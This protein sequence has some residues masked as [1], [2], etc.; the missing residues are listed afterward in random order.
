MKFPGVSIIVIGHNEADHLK[1]CFEAINRI[2]YPK[3]C[4]QIIF[5]DSSSTDNSVDIA[6]SYANKIVSIGSMWSTAGEAFNEG[7][8]CADFDFIHITSGDIQLN[9][10]YLIHAINTL[11]NDS[12]I[13]AVTGYFTEASNK[14]WNKIVGY[15]RDDGTEVKASFV[16]TPNG[17][18]F[19]KKSLFLVNGYD[20]RIKKGQE[21]ELGMRFCEAGLKIWYM[22]IQQGIHDFSISNVLD[23]VAR[24]FID[25]ASNC[26]VFLLSL[27]YNSDDTFNKFAKR[28]KKEASLL[29]IYILLLG[30]FFASNNFLYLFSLVF[31]YLIVLPVKNIF[32]NRTKPLKYK[33]FILLNH[34]FSIFR[35]FGYLY[36][37]FKQIIFIIRKKSL[38]VEK[39]GLLD[40]RSNLRVI[41]QIV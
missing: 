29:F 27:R 22:N 13:S 2:N 35:H 26:H 10:D 3:D 38:I 17:G 12:D 36:F 37:F 33:K 8:K 7:I 23:L 1:S 25:G 15:R 30:L 14:G 16:L 34:L 41:K 24:Y 11:Q 5:V 28:T 20:E 21:T 40:K 18:T 31:I 39:K 19:R 6:K 4:L 32:K 9:A